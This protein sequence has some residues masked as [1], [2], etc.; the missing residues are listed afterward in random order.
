MPGPP[1]LLSLRILMRSIAAFLLPIACTGALVAETSFYKNEHG[2]FSLRPGEDKAVTHLTRV[3][4]IGISL[5]LLQ[6]AFTMRIKSVEPGSPAATAGLEPGMFIESIN[7]GKLADIDPRI[8]LG[9]WITEAEAKDGV[10]KIRVADEPGGA[11]REVV[12]K[13]PVLGAY[14]ETWPLD[15]SKSL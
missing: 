4:P 6:P 3:G 1:A 9:N 7:G 8:Q 13:I 10:L 15:C 2:L 5:D 11:T 14:S 12:V